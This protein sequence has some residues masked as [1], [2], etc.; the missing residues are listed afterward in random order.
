MD[1]RDAIPILDHAIA[2]LENIEPS[3]K[4]CRTCP[5]SGKCCDGAFIE[6]V[7]PEEATAIATYLRDH[8]AKLEYAKKRA[9]ESKNCYF[10]DSTARQC[11]IHE[12]RPILCRWTPYTAIKQYG[13]PV[14]ANYRDA[15]CEFKQVSPLDKVKDIKPGFIEI[16]PFP[17][18]GK[19]QKMLH[20]QG[21]TPLH[22]LLRR[23][24]ECVDMNDVMAMATH[25]A[26]P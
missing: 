6:V 16:V 20:L 22:P 17:G 7:F 2:E 24:N 1:V 10:Y 21:I 14:H 8:P 4:N 18:L 26:N 23:S 19:G 12:V 25:G 15:N 3:W 11:L 13:A 9:E 5:H